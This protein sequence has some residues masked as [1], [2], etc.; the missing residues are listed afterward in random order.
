MSADINMDKLVSEIKDKGHFLT[1]E[2]IKIPED[3]KSIKEFVEH[4]GSCSNDNCEVHK[5]MD[6][7]EKDAMMRGFSLGNKFGN[8]YPRYEL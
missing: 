4:M 7:K 2:D 3:K 8:K 5:A 6:V 1:K